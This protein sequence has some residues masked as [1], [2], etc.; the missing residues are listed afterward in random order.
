PGAERC[1]R[2]SRSTPRC[3]WA[4]WACVDCDTRPESLSTHYGSRLTLS[5]RIVHDLP[6]INF[7]PSGDLLPT[8]IVRPGLLDRLQKNAGLSDGAFAQALNSSPT[9]V[10][11]VRRGEAPSL[12]FIAGVSAA[13]GLSLGEVAIVVE[14]AE[15][16][17]AK[18][19]A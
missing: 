9:T 19:S 17:P 15:S 11:R 8:V 2:R 1:W 6:Q 16:A 4:L 5:L 18:E 7:D 3:L 13:F 14:D 12:A 10:A